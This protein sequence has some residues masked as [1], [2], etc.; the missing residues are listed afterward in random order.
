MRCF[1]IAR[2]MSILW[3][4]IWYSLTFGDAGWLSELGVMDFAGVIVV[5]ITVGVV[6]LVAAM[7]L[8]NR[9]G[10]P[11]QAM[12]PHNM[13]LSIMGAGMLWIG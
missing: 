7:V 9:R 4:V 12:L 6:A 3:L 2:V 11:N 10:F 8:G 13:T 5:H 1:T